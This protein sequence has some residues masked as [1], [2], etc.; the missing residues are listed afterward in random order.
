MNGKI[1]RA[2]RIGMAIAK[3]RCS[4]AGGQKRGETG[5]FSNRKSPEPGLGKQRYVDDK[6]L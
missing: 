1:R 2:H 6:K 3:M 5:P 4:R